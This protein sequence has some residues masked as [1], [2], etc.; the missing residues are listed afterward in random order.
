MQEHSQT[1]PSTRVGSG[2]SPRGFVESTSADYSDTRRSEQ[3]ST[4]LGRRSVIDA[5][6]ARLDSQQRAVVLGG[7]HIQQTVTTLADVADSLPQIRSTSAHGE[8]PATN[9]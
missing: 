2:S 1:E 4:R 5:T 6:S 9:R 8:A 7:E 3:V